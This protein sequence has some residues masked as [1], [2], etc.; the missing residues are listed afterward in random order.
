MANIEREW[1]GYYLQMHPDG[2][3]DGTKDDSTNSSYTSADAGRAS[4]TI[5]SH[6]HSDRRSTCRGLRGSHGVGREEETGTQAELKKSFRKL[7]KKQL[8]DK[9]QHLADNTRQRVQDLPGFQ[10]WSTV[11][12]MMDV[13]GTSRRGTRDISIWFHLFKM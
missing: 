2:A 9:I 1:Q 3:L 10:N 8:M 6:K 7:E 12:L 11:Y 13:C 5:P 4:R